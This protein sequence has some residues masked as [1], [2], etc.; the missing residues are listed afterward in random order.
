M[1]SALI[2][3][4]AQAPQPVRDLLDLEFDATGRVLAFQELMLVVRLEQVHRA[5]VPNICRNR[6][7]W[8]GLPVPHRN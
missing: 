7:P 6:A 2:D 4:A 3:H 5:H 8:I 1:I